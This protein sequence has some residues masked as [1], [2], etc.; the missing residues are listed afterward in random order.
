MER[1]PRSDDFQNVFCR[2]RLAEHG[3]RTSQVS[4]VF[5]WPLYN[6]ML[7]HEILS[8]TAGC[9]LQYTLLALPNVLPY[10]H[11]VG[12]E[13]TA[14]PGSCV[15]SSVWNLVSQSRAF[16]WSVCS[17]V[18]SVVRGYGRRHI[19]SK[20]MSTPSTVYFFAQAASC[21][22]VATGSFFVEMTLSVDQPNSQKPLTIVA[23]GRYHESDAGVVI[24]REDGLALLFGKALPRGRRLCVSTACASR[25]AQKEFR[26]C[27]PPCHILPSYP[28]PG[29]FQPPSNSPA[30]PTHRLRAVR[31]PERHQ[32][33][34]VRLDLVWSRPVAEAEL[35]C[36]V[37][38]SL[39]LSLSGCAPRYGTH[40]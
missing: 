19:P 25:A 39:S 15:S 12:V 13:E 8:P 22:A 2:Q 26:P 27:C 6:C 34:V 11:A 36:G 32:G 21:C 16:A 10:I 38:L 33:A 18:K 20:S 5:G 3:A 9:S 14:K 4:H 30:R 28:R 1:K 17:G 35:I 31:L 24:R 7:Y 37:S 29:Q 23:K 40:Y